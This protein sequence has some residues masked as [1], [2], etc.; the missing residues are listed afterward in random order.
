[1]SIKFQHKSGGVVYSLEGTIVKWQSKNGAEYCTTPY[2]QR[3]IDRYFAD[4]TWVKIEEVQPES[5]TVSALDKY[6][7]TGFGVGI[8]SNEGTTAI[9]S[10]GAS[11]TSLKPGGAVA[12]DGGSSSYYDISLPQ[13]LVDKINERQKDGK[14]FVKTEELIEVAFA[15]DFD[16]SN[17]FKSLIR[18][19]GAFNGAGKKGNSVDY[20]L[21]KMN[22]STEKLRSRNQRKLNVGKWI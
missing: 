11:V 17:I 5:T 15:N 20:D 19:W 14:A 2:A 10:Q 22:Y 18:A 6:Y 8:S 1:M 21:N 12:S 16:A 9:T 3:K 7:I 13:W 4:G